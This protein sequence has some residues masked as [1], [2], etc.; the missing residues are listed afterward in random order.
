MRRAHS[1]VSFPAPDLTAARDQFLRENRF[2]EGVRPLVRESWLRSRLYGVDPNLLGTQH[3]D[4]DRLGRLRAESRLLLDRAEPFLLAAHETMGGEAH[5]LALADARGNILRLLAGPGLPLDDRL[6]SNLFEGASW[7]EGDIG[8]NGVGTA[9]AVGEPVIL[10][11][12]E[13]FQEAYVGWTCIGVPLRDPAGR[14]VGALDLSVPND[15][16]NVHAWGWSLSLAHGIERALETEEPSTRSPGPAET[17]PLDEPLNAVRGVF[18]LLATTLD[19]PPTHSG[20]IEQGLEA[21]DAAEDRIRSL[22]GQLD[23]RAQRSRRELDELEAIYETA[24]IGLCVVDR[25]LRFVRIND[26]LAAINGVPVAEHLGR[27]VREVLPGFADELEPLLQRA[28]QG[29]AVLGLE[30]SGERP[31]SPGHTCHWVQHCLPLKDADGVAWGVNVV[32]ED[33]TERMRMRSNLERLREEVVSIVKH[34]VRTPLHVVRLAARLLARS[35]LDPE[36]RTAQASAIDRSVA[37]MERLVGDLFELTT[38]GEGR[39]SISPDASDPAELIREAA[40]L[41][42]ALTESRPIS[43]R[44]EVA[45]RLPFV[46]ADEVRTLQVFGNLLRNAVQAMEGGGEITLL[47]ALD[48]DAVRFSVRDSGSGFG[49]GEVESAFE[50]AW[51]GHRRSE[52]GAGL[53]LSICKRIVEAQNGRIWIDSNPGAGATVHFTLPLHTPAEEA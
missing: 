50:P 42:K 37:Q 9:L 19:L 49:P 39:L 48:G 30:L 44:V 21:V 6:K 52:Q 27:S 40:I 1:T 46:A 43:V 53:G 13:H 14:I 35:D 11:G 4:P 47:A 51:Q 26:R 38:M 5:I 18:E 29:E 15:R 28:L 31:G 41:A 22:L 10:I 32:V 8:C 24:P 36:A 2:A 17:F 23:S 3:P 20:Y 33:V 16:V 25:S 12:P 7:H 45:D 34:D